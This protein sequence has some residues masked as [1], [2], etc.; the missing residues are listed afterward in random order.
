MG[1]LSGLKWPR[2][3]TSGSSCEHNCHLDSTKSKNFLP[4][5]STI[6]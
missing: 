3:G 1:V 2:I 6:I 4:R 5:L